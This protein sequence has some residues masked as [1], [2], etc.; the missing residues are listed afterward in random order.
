MSRSIL[1]KAE[2]PRLPTPPC[3]AKT[4]SCIVEV[5]AILIGAN[6]T[7]GVAVH[8]LTTAAVFET[9]IAAD[10]TKIIPGLPLLH[11]LTPG[12][13]PRPGTIQLVSAHPARA[14][15][16]H[17]CAGR[18]TLR[19]NAWFFLALGFFSCQRHV[20]L[21]LC[22]HPC[23][24]TCNLVGICILLSHLLQGEVI[25][26]R[27]RWTRNAGRTWHAGWN[28]GGA[29]RTFRTQKTGSLRRSW[30]L[31]GLGL[32]LHEIS[33]LWRHAQWCVKW[34]ETLLTPPEL[35]HP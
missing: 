35:R 25:C 8:P 30:F 26:R 27:V 33:R 7:I 19:L 22:P 16:A 24:P 32:R 31:R 5:P 23:T 12:G 3:V 9:M 15:R 18:R 28:A 10:Y 34:D 2:R 17:P 29:A 20:L 4:A 21:H 13:A 6:P 11:Q 1:A 14:R